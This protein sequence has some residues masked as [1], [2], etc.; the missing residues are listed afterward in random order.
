ML[1]TG[2][3]AIEW[4]ASTQLSLILFGLLAATSI[5]G[6]L[7][8]SQRDYYS[9]P[10]FTLLL[11]A[12][13]L[14]L[15][16]CTVKRWQ[17]LSRSTLI[18]HSGVLITIVGAILTGT[19]YV[20]TVNIYEGETTGSVYRWDLKQDIAATNGIRIKK[21][22]T[23]FHPV[24]LKIGVLKGDRKYDLKTLKTGETFQLDE[25]SV[26]ADRFDP[27]RE[28]VTLNIMKG[29]QIIGSAD[30]LGITNTP[31]GFPYSFKLV[32]FQ[33]A[34]IK[35]FWVDM[36]LLDNGHVVTS[37]ITEINHPFSWNGVDYFNTEVSIDEEKRPYA[38]IQLVRD[39][40]K[41]VVYFGMFILSVGTIAAWYRRFK[42]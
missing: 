3:K 38:G 7:L 26:K 36:E 42:R 33:T 41:Y 12:F 6:T 5:P 29:S 35:R 30:T 16:I 19:G 22:N 20:A 32:A 28:A 31:E 9:H 4:L 23:E 39:P 25:Y 40:G 15:A 13:T 18:V 34:V 1:P 11:G 24:P 8:K 14:H 2:K 10:A 37:G 21:I 17:S 27:W